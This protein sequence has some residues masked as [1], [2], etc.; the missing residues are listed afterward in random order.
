MVHL[1]GSVSGQP[2]QRGTDVGEL[3]IGISGPDHVLCIFCKQPVHFFTLSE[4]LL[5]LSAHRDI[6]RD[7]DNFRKPSCCR[8]ADSPA[9]GFEPYIISVFTPHPV[10]YGHADACLFRHRGMEALNRGEVI[11]M[12]LVIKIA[13]QKFFGFVAQ[14]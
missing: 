3:H 2:F 14:Q 8:V 10:R 13:S 6:P 12:K 5:F 9:R 4:S 11:R 7:P 1:F